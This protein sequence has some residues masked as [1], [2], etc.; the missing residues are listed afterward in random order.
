MILWLR[1][2]ISADDMTW[3]KSLVNTLRAPNSYLLTFEILIS[4][5]P[6]SKQC[7]KLHHQALLCRI[8]Q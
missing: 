3:F 5:Y 1:T 8:D 7:Y 6:Y 4:I 2:K